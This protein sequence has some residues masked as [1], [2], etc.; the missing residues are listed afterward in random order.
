MVRRQRRRT[1]FVSPPDASIVE[2][3]SQH[4]QTVVFGT[5]DLTPGGFQAHARGRGKR[6]DVLPPSFPGV[7]R[8]RWSFSSALGRSTKPATSESCSCSSRTVP[9]S[10]SAVAVSW[11]STSIATVSATGSAGGKRVNGRRRQAKGRARRCLEA[12]GP[13]WQRLLLNVAGQRRKQ[14][15]DP[16]SLDGEAAVHVR[17]ANRELRIKKQPVLQPL[18]GDD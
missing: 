1:L 4:F 15:V 10:E 18:I 2:T 17:F 13:V 7:T 3:L 14:I 5:I 11:I 16:P 6:S 8:C 12:C 9:I